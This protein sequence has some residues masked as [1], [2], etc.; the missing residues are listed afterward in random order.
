MPLSGEVQ[1]EEKKIFRE[2]GELREAAKAQAES[3]FSVAA[4]TLARMLLAVDVPGGAAS[5]QG[6]CRR[7]QLPARCRWMSSVA[8]GP[9]DAAR[10]SW[11]GCGPKGPWV[12]SVALLGLGKQ[13][14]L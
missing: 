6:L 5:P 11:G 8:P 12:G 1:G 7:R 2:A 10:A 14:A 9:R 13:G 3:V 4:A